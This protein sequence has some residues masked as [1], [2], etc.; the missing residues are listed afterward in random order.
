MKTYYGHGKLM[1]TG[2]YVV[3]K[4]AKTLA[5]PT[6]FGQKFDVSGI[7]EPEVLWKSYDPT[8]HCWLTVNLSLPKLRLISATYDVESEQS[9]HDFAERLQELLLKVRA[10]NPQF[11]EEDGGVMVESFLEFNRDW[12]LG[13]S[14]T[15]IYFLSRWANVDPYIL[16]NKTFGGSGYDLA[17]AGS[18]SPLIYQLIKGQPFV[19]KMD[20]QPK[21]SN[22]L[23]FVHLNKKMNSRKGI[24]HFLDQDQSRTDEVIKEID[25]ITKQVGRC[26]LLVE[27][28]TLMHRHEELIASLLQMKTIKEELFPDY[29]GCVKSLG[30][31]GGDFILATG[32]RDYFKEKGYSTIIEYKDMIL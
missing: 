5:L 12:G 13:S 31:W 15:L 9:D 21:F 22:D 4:G 7:D 30:A 6:R 3:L 27:F 19:E 24:K 23:F 32:S 2:E 29:S 11:L 8:G 20:F 28:E 16:L 10:L 14:S 26:E 1:L 18:S 17:C 25:G